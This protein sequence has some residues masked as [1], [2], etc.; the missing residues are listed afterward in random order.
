M[1]YDISALNHEWRDNIGYVPQDIFIFN[2]TV[3]ENIALGIPE[4]KIDYDR[5]KFVLKKACLIDYIEKLEHKEKS[6]IGDSG[7]MFSGGQIQRIGIARALYLNP[8]I[9]IL[10]E[11]TSA[12]DSR[13][14]NQIL[15]EIKDISSEL[16][17]I[18]ITHKTKPLEI[19]NIICEVIDQTIIT[20]NKLS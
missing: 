5:I 7:A 10:D 14:E 13:T 4:E 1:K 19:C 20:K 3:A 2:G 6:R 16:T 12:L 8:K 9:L 18:F 15:T 11:A 17:V